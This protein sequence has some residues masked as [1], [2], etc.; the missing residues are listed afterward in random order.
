MEHKVDTLARSWW[1]LLLRGLVAIGFAIVAWARPGPTLAILVILFG[2]YA[3]CDGIA[4]LAG[5]VRA[6]RREEGW[7]LLAA[8]G[9]FG[10]ALGLFTLMAP[11][12]ALTIA[13]VMIAIWALCTGVLEIIE[14]ARLRRY[15][16]GELLL[17]LSGVVRILFGVLLL[18][19]P[20]A[21]VLTLLWIAAAY[22]LA[23]GILLIGLSLRLKRHGTVRR[24]VGP[25]GITPQPA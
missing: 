22:A 7:G 24:Q 18:A 8:E 16:P 5:A 3:I 1:A 15:I 13:F 21:G 19:R 14:A 17:V 11:A 23:D 9:F 20:G 10:I 25:G 4:A 12:K 2:L 6:G